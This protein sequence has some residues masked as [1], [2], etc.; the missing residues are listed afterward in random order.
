MKPLSGPKQRIL[1][2][3]ASFLIGGYGV[4]F[5]FI[6]TVSRD[7]LPMRLALFTYG[8]AVLFLDRLWKAVSGRFHLFF[9]GFGVLVVVQSQLNMALYGVTSVSAIMAALSAVG[10]SFFFQNHH[11][12]RIYLV[13]YFLL[14]FGVLWVTP[15]NT[16]GL[17]NSIFLTVTCG[18]AQGVL[19]TYVL[20]MGN[21]IEKKSLTTQTILAGARELIWGVDRDLRVTLFSESA[22][23]YFKHFY[24]KDFRVGQH[25]FEDYAE[26][27][28][29]RWTPY[30]QRA[31]GGELVEME[32]QLPE[33]P[34]T[35]YAISFSP[36]QNA[37][38][39]IY[40]VTGMLRDVSEDRAELRRLI[41]S[42]KVSEESL[43]LKRE[44]IHQAQ[45]TLLHLIPDILPQSPKT[46]FAAVY[47][48]S[49]ELSGDFF[50]IVRSGNDSIILIADCSGH[51]IPASLSAVLLRAV[52]DNHLPEFVGNRSPGNFLD[53]IS[54][55][56]ANYTQEGK[57][58]SL[59]AG[60]FDKRTTCLTYASSGAKTP[61]LLRNENVMF[62]PS[63]PGL[64]L[65]FDTGQK[66]DERFHQ[67]Q[68]AD[69]IFFYSDALVEIFDD[70]MGD[71]RMRE[72]ELL[73]MLTRNKDLS[74]ESL[75]NTV[76]DQ[77]E[78]IAGKLPLK[79][80]L[81]M[82]SFRFSE[83]ISG[84][85]QDS[86]LSV[87]TRLGREEIL[88]A[89]EGCDWNRDEIEEVSLAYGEITLNAIRHGNLD[90]L[91]KKV[92]VSYEIDAES[93]RIR[94]EDEGEGFS[95]SIVP[96]PVE[97]ARLVSRMDGEGLEKMFHGRGVW[98]CRNIFLDELIYN[99]K[100][101]KAT[102]IKKKRARR[103]RKVF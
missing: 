37:D 97:L 17:Q 3:T 4:Y 52:C 36:V 72:N 34:E 62:L 98:M 57:F 16:I 12:F 63:S 27:V 2:L 47:L 43:R 21:E 6:D 75:L 101:N 24:G 80:D 61:I 67:L 8:V 88:S 68:P 25:I 85:F 44:E 26:E 48:P 71:F 99:D 70:E 91:S 60:Y 59:F 22:R 29:R 102:L 95:P 10:A 32:Y 58:H 35:I 46:S 74:C 93:V 5:H 103:T 49:A 33:N 28:I 89:M 41:Q 92:F 20:A 30:Y 23:R 7:F 78:D 19:V 83:M 65:G 51:G 79:D 9:S 76:L 77:L 11:H 15:E 55:D 81:T 14:S 1:L 87:L 50:Q 100:G 13:F 53:K 82:I 18:I 86:D 31:L 54:L 96:D 40:G 38:G 66:Y 90:S 39:I 73:M 64:P 56:M 45:T 84:S 69:R 42:N 94:I